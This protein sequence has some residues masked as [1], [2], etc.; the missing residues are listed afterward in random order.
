M[1]G[2][3]NREFTQRFILTNITLALRFSRE[4]E[5]AH[6]WAPCAVMISYSH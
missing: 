3:L 4:A 5:I 2:E 6:S 1:L